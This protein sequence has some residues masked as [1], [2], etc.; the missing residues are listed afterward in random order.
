MR[1]RSGSVGRPAAPSGRE[2]QTEI[3]SAG[4]FGQ[5]PRTPIAWDALERRA[6]RAMSRAA[7]AYVAGG[8]GREL[9][10]AANR[11][12][13]DEWQLV[14][15]VL[16]D[17]STRTLQTQLLGRSLP[18]PI[19]LGPVGVS[20]MAH[21]GADVAAARA[22]AELGIPMVFSNQASASMEDCAA[23]MGDAPRWF[24]LYW[25]TIDEL[26]ESFLHRAAGCGCAAIVVTLDTTMLGWRPRDLD[27][28]SLPFARGWGLAQY[29]SDPVFM[30][31]ARERA[32]DPAPAPAPRPTPAALRTLLD[33][34]R[35]HPGRTLDNLRSRVPRAAVELFLQS[36]S[37]PSIT[38]DDL[39]W[40]RA[41]T[42][43]PIILKGILH[44]DDA[45]RALDAGMDGIVVSTHGGR[46][47]DGSI[48]AG[49]ALPAVAAAVAG[50]VPVLLDSGV[51]T[52]ADV[53]K[54]LALGADAVLVG[55]PWVYG[56]AVGGADGVR[57]VL[58]NLIAE[59]DLT[60]ALTGCT[61]VTQ[62]RELTLHR[63]G[64]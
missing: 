60:L 48:G 2:R 35:A 16:R 44:P 52:G 46:Q 5:R 59:L 18:A 61:S 10:M 58:R 37:R 12:G 8:A 54:A 19:L 17:V 34:S 15:R 4:V 6:R 50:R 29:T 14:P 47:V 41:R 51:R 23:V 56:L 27:L 7:F 36:Y 1:R 25:S 26:V 9:T 55:R 49:Q 24:Q 20:A 64:D 28:A 33:I 42:E 11:A 63:R 45:R 31:L 13:L 57:D 21:R 3:Y 32:G 40:L 62:A 39:P 30:R 38:W 53:L 22:C 43:L